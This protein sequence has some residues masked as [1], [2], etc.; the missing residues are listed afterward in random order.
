MEDGLEYENT[1]A[2]KEKQELQDAKLSARTAAGQC[3]PNARSN[4]NPES[5]LS[6]ISIKA[7]YTN[8]TL[9]RQLTLCS[10]QSTPKSSKQDQRLDPVTPTSSWSRMRPLKYENYEHLLILTAGD[11]LYNC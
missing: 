6:Q 2:V 9:C 5:D 11:E 7:R 4:P 1:Y 8:P 10:P 3:N